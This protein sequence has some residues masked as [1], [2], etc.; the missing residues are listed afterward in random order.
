VGRG[1]LWLVPGNCAFFR[2]AAA[3]LVGRI[4][5]GKQAISLHAAVTRAAS[6]L[7]SMVIGQFQVMVMKRQKMTYTVLDSPQA[8]VFSHTTAAA[9][10]RDQCRIACHPAVHSALSKSLLK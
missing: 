8:L 6:T 5:S 3:G 7:S 1:Q 10:Y 9:L 2:A 4:A